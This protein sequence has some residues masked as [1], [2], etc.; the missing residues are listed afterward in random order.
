MGDANALQLFKTVLFHAYHVFACTKVNKEIVCMKKHTIA[1][2]M[3]TTLLILAGCGSDV[4]QNT[5][6][7]NTSDKTN[8]ESASYGTVEG[9]YIYRNVHDEENNRDLLLKYSVKTGEVDTVCQDPFCT[10]SDSDCLFY[11]KQT[12]QVVYI[13]NTVYFTTED[14]SEHDIICAYDPATMQAEA[15]FSTEDKIA[16]VFQYSY[17]LYIETNTADENVERKI[18]RLNTQTQTTQEIKF[19]S[20]ADIYEIKYDRITWKK[21]TAYYSTDLDGKTKKNMEN[22]KDVLGYVY[23]SEVTTEGF[24]TFRNLTM[25]LYRR[26]KGTDNKIKIASGIGPYTFYRDKI[27]YF[28]PLPMEEQEKIYSDSSRTDYDCYGGNVYIMDLDGD[29]ASLLC[30]AENCYISGMSSDRYN[31]WC[32]GDWIGIML[33]DADPYSARDFA[34]MLI[35]NVATGE[36]VVCRY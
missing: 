13:G 7:T 28:V 31:E 18:I 11:L 36:Y 5:S 34:D 6:G 25:D 24:I 10:H 26:E 1:A 16:A 35:V 14:E 33:K 22:N 32:C 2:M 8:Y 30:H 23:D 19:D 9:E 12:S 17:D 29:N 20:N 3:L 21:G 27:L 15:V 4:P